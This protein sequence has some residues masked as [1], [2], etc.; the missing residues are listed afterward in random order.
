VL[1]VLTGPA[2]DPA[3]DAFAPA[4]SDEAEFVFFDWVLEVVFAR[5]DADFR[6][7]REARGFFGSWSAMAKTF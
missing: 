6:R 7:V 5:D 2:P 4:V 1:P 3:P